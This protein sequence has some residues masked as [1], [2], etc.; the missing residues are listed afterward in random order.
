MGPRARYSPKARCFLN[1]VS[2]VRFLPGARVLWSPS[3]VPEGEPE[4]H[5][6]LQDL[7]GTG[8]GLSADVV[9]FVAARTSTPERRRR[10][11]DF[12]EQVAR[13]P[14]VDARVG[15][16]NQTK[17]GWAY[18][19]SLSRRGV[20]GSFLYAYASSLKVLFRLE[21][22]DAVS[23]EPLELR[24]IRADAKYRVRASLAN[25]PGF[26][27]CLKLAK[28]AYDKTFGTPGGGSEGS[29]P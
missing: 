20:G 7:G 4:G 8:S 25:D 17:D 3:P 16:S 23:I 6:S 11:Q 2:R 15:R 18:S 13:W 12:L 22:E 28:R 9:A 10:V 1:R 21:H 27:A 29:N 26:D 19:V 24:D 14:G 5:R